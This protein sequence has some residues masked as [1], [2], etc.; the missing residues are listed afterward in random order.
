MRLTS[1][2][3]VAAFMRTEQGMGAYVV[4]AQSGAEAA[5][6]IFIV[7][8]HLDN[9]FSLLSPAPQALFGAEDDGERKFERVIE[10]SSEQ[11]V[12]EYLGRQKKF[13]ADIW[14]VEVESKAETLHLQIAESSN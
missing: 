3:W 5:G 11:E 8:N 4:L 9:S 7:Q 10:R 1:K 14:I 12:L 2:M 13:D 6:A